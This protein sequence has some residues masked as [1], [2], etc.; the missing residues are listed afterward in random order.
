MK[1]S[2]NKIVIETEF[3]E[4]IFEKCEQHTVDQP[5][6]SVSVICDDGKKIGI[7]CVDTKDLIEL[8]KLM[9]KTSKN[10]T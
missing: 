10:Q 3:G 6:F 9:E 5:H 2:I 8:G 1:V 4:L 7:G